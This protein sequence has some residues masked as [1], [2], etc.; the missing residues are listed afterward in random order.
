MLSLDEAVARSRSRSRSLTVDEGD[1]IQ[2]LRNVLEDGA[3]AVMSVHAEKARRSSAVT[4]SSLLR[5]AAV[6]RSH[7]DSWME[8]K[9]AGGMTG[10][11]PDIAQISSRRTDLQRDNKSG[12]SSSLKPKR[13]GTVQSELDNAKKSG[14]GESNS[15]EDKEES[16]QDAL[17]SARKRMKARRNLTRTMSMRFS[18]EGNLSL[19]DR[20]RG[21]SALEAK[22]KEQE[23]ALP[24]VSSSSDE[25]EYDSDEEKEWGRGSQR[26]R[27]K[28]KG[29][30]RERGSEREREGKN[31]KQPSP[32]LPGQ[33]ETEIKREEE[34]SK[35]GGEG[36]VA[37]DLTSH[38][39]ESM[40]EAK[41]GGGGEGEG[42]DG[43]KSVREE[44][45]QQDK[46]GG[47]AVSEG[48]EGTKRGW[49][50]VR[51]KMMP[52]RQQSDVSSSLLALTIPTKSSSGGGSTSNLFALT[53]QVMTV[54]QINKLKLKVF[55]A[56]QDAMM[57]RNEKA[58]IGVRLGEEI[59]G[60][61][62]EVERLSQD[63]SV[64]KGHLREAQVEKDM[65]ERKAKSME[66]NFNNTARELEALRSSTAEVFKE[67][68]ELE[69]LSRSLASQVRDVGIAKMKVEDEVKMLKT[70]LEN[71]RK[72]HEQTLSV[73][74]QL[75]ASLRRSKGEVE[76]KKETIHQHESREQ[77]IGSSLIPIL[78]EV[79]DIVDIMRRHQQNARLLNTYLSSTR[80]VVF[81]RDKLAVL[82]EGV[83]R[84][85]RKEEGMQARCA[86]NAIL[87]ADRRG[88]VR[89]EKELK[90]DVALE[91][92]TTTVQD[93]VKMM[94]KLDSKRSDTVR[95]SMMAKREKW[96]ELLACLATVIDSDPSLADESMEDSTA[97]SLMP[98]STEVS[99]GNIP[100]RARARPMSAVDR[101]RLHPSSAKAD[102]AAK[103]RPTSAQQ[104]SSFQH[105]GRRLHT[106]NT[107]AGTPRSHLIS[108]KLSSSPYAPK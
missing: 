105:R 30:Q 73:C 88:L 61:K 107:G 92:L 98:S 56:E 82:E 87:T 50:T 1:Q 6:G 52:A 74:A 10:I 75:R 5:R 53:K 12:T 20:L 64:M 63:I 34:A 77:L 17:E 35:D 2:K 40:S 13:E 21:A 33:L 89:S 4:P 101:L 72:K 27:G 42:E 85:I 23:L 22:Q 106:T 81:D 60:W 96:E 44:E 11:S 38:G 80:E 70:E 55:K 24:E 67:R 28:G 49:S 102:S 37:S 26:T 19:L 83:Q 48:G 99:R 39:V 7:D 79:L 31:E 69:V 90:E 68:D 95:M 54:K 45:S 8:E 47:E 3:K 15:D 16:E 66:E 59:Q 29:S 100:G 78:E 36:G 43:T 71:T 84:F 104:R 76:E 97:T 58:A 103:R 9:R 108:P 62:R 94:V 91:R 86:R 25:G 32:T 93:L 51:A 18:S 65:V 57:L 14:G 46:T 41:G